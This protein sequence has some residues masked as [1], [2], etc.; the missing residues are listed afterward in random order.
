[1]NKNTIPSDNMQAA[2]YLIRV[3]YIVAGRL[4]SLIS[5]RTAMIIVIYVK[6]ARV[7]ASIPTV[8]M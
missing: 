2:L 5:V 8:N 3:P 6:Y 4:E 1:V 7:L